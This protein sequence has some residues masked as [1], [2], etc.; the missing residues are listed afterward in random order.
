[1]QV[2]TVSVFLAVLSPVG[3]IIPEREGIRV[4]AIF[5]GGGAATGGV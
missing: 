5:E 3:V 4:C 1:M 2:T